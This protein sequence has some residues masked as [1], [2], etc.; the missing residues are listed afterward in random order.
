MRTCE[1]QAGFYA[2]SNKTIMAPFVGLNLGWNWLKNTVLVELLWEKN[3]IPTEKTSRT[4]RFLGK[5]NGANIYI[6][7]VDNF[8]DGLYIFLW[9]ELVMVVYIMPLCLW[10]DLNYIYIYIYVCVCVCSGWIW[11]INLNFFNG[12]IYCRDGS[13][14]NRPYKQVLQGRLVLQPPL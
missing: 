14:L 12:K 8:N 11:I 6:K 10:S 2:R 4:S 7:L 9:I 5:P 3:T 13:R 1:L